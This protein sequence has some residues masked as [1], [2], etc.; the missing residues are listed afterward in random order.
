MFVVET[1]TRNVKREKSVKGKRVQVDEKR[2]VFW[3][4]DKLKI[5][6]FLDDWI[7]W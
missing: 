5:Y 2:R 6:I 7:V 1:F 3:S 4:A